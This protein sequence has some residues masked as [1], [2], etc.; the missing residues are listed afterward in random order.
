MQF[1]LE[2]E[3]VKDAKNKAFIAD[4]NLHVFTQVGKYYK[5]ALTSTGGE[6]KCNSIR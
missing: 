3:E 6:L 1:G 2:N 4:G 5:T